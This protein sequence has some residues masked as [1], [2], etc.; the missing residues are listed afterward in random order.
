MATKLKFLLTAKPL[1]LAFKALIFAASPALVRYAGFSAGSLA[2]FAAANFYLYWSLIDRRRFRT[3]YLVLLTIGFLAGYSLL[4]EWT[5]AV[6]LVYLIVLA[7]LLF[8]LAEFWF[9]NRPAVYQILNTAL[10]FAVFA[11]FFSADPAR[12]FYGK[13]LIVALAVYLLFREAFQFL[14]GQWPRREAVIA[15]ALALAAFE[16]LWAVSLSPIGFI[17]SAALLTLLV[18]LSRDLIWQYLQGCL[19]RSVILKRATFFVVLLVLI[20]GTSN[21]S[22]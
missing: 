3:S 19:N 4:A 6:A 7:Y 1:R 17:N 15:L 11:I 9:R 8:G 5:F 18:F 20:L 21:W 13:Y 16:M 12:Y 22:L 10:F 14:S 2:L